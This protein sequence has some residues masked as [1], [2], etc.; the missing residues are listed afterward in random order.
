MRTEHEFEQI[1]KL[2]QELTQQGFTDLSFYIKTI[3]KKTYSLDQKGIGSSQYASDIMYSI[4]GTLQEKICKIYTNQVE[5]ARE[6]ARLMEAAAVDQEQ[7]KNRLEIPERAEGQEQMFQWQRE[8][9]VLPY[10]EEAQTLAQEEGN[11]QF[12]HQCTY[13]QHKEEICLIDP[14]FHVMRDYDGYHCFRFGVTAGNLLQRETVLR[15]MYGTC[16][17]DMDLKGCVKKTVQETA[18][19]VGSGGTEP[20]RSG[21]YPAILSGAVMAE[22]IDAFL[23]AFFGENRR[24]GMSGLK[25]EVGESAASDHIW[26]REV[27]DLHGARRRR[28]IDDEGTPTSDKYL[29]RNGILQE[30][31]HNRKTAQQENTESTGNGF[32]FSLQSNVATGVTNL[33]F[34]SSDEAKR[35]TLKELEQELQEGI[36]VTKVDGVFAGADSVTGEFSLI[37]GGK[38]ICGGKEEGSFREVT[39]SGN[40]FDL[41][42]RIKKVSV[43]TQTTFPDIASVTA[44]AVAVG[45]MIVSGK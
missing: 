39:I 6:I 24:E 4:E 18:G 43:D 10:L 44:P 38:R 23:P 22:L 33:L 11:V 15:C 7:A 8:E 14:E 27:P 5:D 26:L 13:E 41:L 31:L 25:A 9:E 36:L 42:K 21:V 12:V 32:R 19:T 20:L 30:I 2:T 40:F 37:A 29:I 3:E 35:K 45:D 16:V 34:G 1:K 28:T 17:Q